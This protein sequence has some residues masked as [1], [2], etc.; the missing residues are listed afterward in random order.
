MGITG[1][2]KGLQF[3]SH[4]RHIRD[5]SNQ[6][7]AVDAS[8]WLH[9]SVYSISERYVESLDKGHLDPTCVQV[10]TKYIVGRC[11]E[12]LLHA[13]IGRIYLVLDGKRC[14]LKAQTNEEREKR[15]QKN[16]AEAR[17]YKREGRR[18]KAEEKYK[19]C[20]KIISAMANAVAE[21]V[22]RR[23]KNDDRVQCINSPYEADAQL[24]KLCMDRVAHAVVT[25][26]RREIAYLLAAFFATL[27]TPPFH[28]FRTLTYWYIRPLV[29]FRFLL[30]T[31][32]RGIQEHAMLYQWNGS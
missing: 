10:A 29:T 11:E 3:C 26:V 19:A 16:L 14:P 30:Y 23:F 20:I 1:L 13:H 6:S 18:D 27:T 24:V 31:S 12:L 8:S 15:R 5:F 7:L 21:A 17:K 28:L 4:K 9:K 25:E 32:S 2:L 22:T